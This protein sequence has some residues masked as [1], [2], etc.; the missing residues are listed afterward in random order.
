V[1]DALYLARKEFRYWFRSWFTWVWVC[2]MPIVFF[3]FIGTVTGGFSRPPSAPRIGLYA[4]PDAGFLVDEFASR[5]AAAGYQVDRVDAQKLASYPRRISV[6]AGFTASV[7]AGKPSK[8]SF[9]RTGGGQGAQYDQIRVERA[10][11][12]VL[13]DLIV[14]SAQGRDATPAAFQAVAATPRTVTLSVT[15]AG[16]RKTIPSG[17]QQ[18][19]P[20]TMVM[21]ILL[22]MFTT[23]GITLY[24]DRTLGIL[25]RL[26][27]SPMSRGSVVL[28]KWLCRLGLGFVQ[29]AFAI[30][31]GFLL[32]RVDWGP[33]L[34]TVLLV[35]AAYAGLA[36]S[37]GM[38]LGN[39]GKT[40]GQV[41]GLGVILSNVLAAIGGCWW[42][43]EVTPEWA[44]KLALV[45][46]TGWAMDALHKL[47]SFGD[48]PLAVAPHLAA[49]L[50]GVAAASYVVARK[51]RFQ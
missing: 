20:G 16:K 33:H 40:E 32:F 5:L 35:L 46:P 47:V 18:A 13:A 29:I 26:A 1:R 10:A 25:R 44:Q 6:P 42:P 24:Q 49:L 36:A 43:I 14:V 28:G 12:S 45:L 50:A 34:V 51:F 21:F 3:Y 19:V 7:L 17:F 27:S 23:G 31:A 22:T 39:F 41:V 30:L 37:A 4:P 15:P 48:S 2:V 11:Y 9:S 38:L 8:L